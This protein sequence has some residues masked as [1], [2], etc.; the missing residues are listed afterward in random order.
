MDLASAR[1]LKALVMKDILVPVAGSAVRRRTV[2]VAAQPLAEVRSQPPRTFA[3]GIARHRKGY[4]LALRLQRRE[5]IRGDLV[6]RIRA[7]ARGEVDMRY[8]GR[9]IKRADVPWYRQ[10]TRP[11]LIGASIAHVQVTAGT[12]GAF[13]RRG[14]G[15]LM[16][17]SNNHVLA[18]END[19]EIGDP[20]LQPGPYDGGRKHEDVVGT[21]AA[22]VRLRPRGVNL[23]DGAVALLDPSVAYAE[24]K[25]EGL[26][27]LAGLG[28]DLAESGAQVAKIGR[29]SGITRGRVTAFELDNVIVSYGMGNLRFDNQVEIEGAGAE[30][31][32]APGDS[33]A[34]VLDDALNAVAL[35]FAG[36]DQG[37]KNG[38]GLTYA[39][40]I[41][42]V[43]EA[44]RVS[45]VY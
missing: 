19:A 37:G 15:P 39:T 34:I 38:Q 22:F 31:F 2:N 35:L 29:T 30:A 45:L 14:R 16:V 21:L 17:L 18:N 28:P 36:A 33:G 9:I 4:R 12:L 3:I 10:R 26:G 42:Q 1:Q 27:R 6:R 44:L 41:R 8:I 40:P 43:L 11:L 25:L 32:S 5:L 13:V 24:D 23:V 20:I 7:M